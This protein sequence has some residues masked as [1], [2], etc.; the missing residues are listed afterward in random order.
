MKIRPLAVEGAWEI[1]PQQHA[2]PRGSFLEWYRPD[3]LAEAGVRPFP[4]AQANLSVSAA[5]VVRGVHFADVPPGQAKYIT[6]V[7][8]AAWDVVVD[9]RVG[10]PTFGRWDAVLLDTVDRRALHLAEGLGHAF[11]SL[12]DDTTVVYFCSETYAPQREH[13]VHPLDPDLAITWPVPIPLL[14]DRDA[15]AP[16]LAELLAAGRLP[17]YDAGAGNSM[18]AASP[19]SLTSSQRTS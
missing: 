19:N 2:D 17:R 18:A 1:T 10:S 12:T 13:T 5:D 14:S 7:T 8:G 3:R 6:C 4:T 9:L 15:A 16:S 11:C